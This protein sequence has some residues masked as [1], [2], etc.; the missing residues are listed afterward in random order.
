[1]HNDLL[2]LNQSLCELWFYEDTE[3]EMSLENN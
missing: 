3:P 2:Y 1:M